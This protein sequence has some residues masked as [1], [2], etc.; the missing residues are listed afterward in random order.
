MLHAVMYRSDLAYLHNQLGTIAAS[1]TKNDE[2]VEHFERALEIGELDTTTWS[3]YATALH[4][5]GQPQ[6]AAP[7][8]RKAVELGEAALVKDPD[9]PEILAGVA[10]S[11]GMLGETERGLEL[12]EKAARQTITDPEI[13]AAVAESFEDLGSR[14]R[15]LE[16]IGRALKDGLPPVWVE[17]RPSL[18]EMRADPRYQAAVMDRFI[19]GSKRKEN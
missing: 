2:A 10:G 8:F 16:W 13:M 5:G 4:F 17:R 11:L 7:A 15:A 14:D 3:F 19:D 1:L 6:R 9:N 12:A 18:Q